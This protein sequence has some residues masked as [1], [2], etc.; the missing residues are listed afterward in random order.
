MKKKQEFTDSRPDNDLE[1]CEKL[2]CLIE[3]YQFCPAVLSPYL[4]LPAD[5]IERLASGDTAL[6][7][8]NP[9]CRFQLYN[10]IFFLLLTATEDKDL[11]LS[12]FLQVLI[13][14][15]HLSS[16]TI[17]KMAGVDAAEVDGLLS[18]PPGN[19][20]IEAKYKIAVTV[21]S[22]RFFLKD[23]EPD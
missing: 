4:C 7:P 16:E 20:S 22:L 1:I 19:I 14:Y 21:M 23:C 3:N 11:K 12:A 2:K 15:H 9:D 5:A 17:A 6:L 13:S 10:K 18:A 8:E